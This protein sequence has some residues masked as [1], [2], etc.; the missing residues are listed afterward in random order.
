MQPKEVKE[1][2]L[3]QKEIYLP[4]EYD[5]DLHKDCLDAFEYYHKEM[6]TEDNAFTK[7]C[8]KY[9]SNSLLYNEPVYTIS[10]GKYPKYDIG[11]IILDC[12]D[13]N[14]EQFT[15]SEIIEKCNFQSNNVRDIEASYI[16]TESLRILSHRWRCS[17]YDK[18]ENTS[19]YMNP[20]NYGT[21]PETMEDLYLYDPVSEYHQSDWRS[22]KSPITSQSVAPQSASSKSSSARSSSLLPLFSIHL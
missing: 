4:I 21:D 19:K 20:E 7:E 8:G 1:E 9:F 2:I 15:I 3:K 22:Y 17:R 18:Y 14:K 11:N 16:A 10:N 6:T 13:N 12:V 5:G